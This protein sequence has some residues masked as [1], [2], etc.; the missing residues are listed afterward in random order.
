MAE[1]Q[2]FTLNTKEYIVSAIDMEIQAA[3]NPCP[4]PFPGTLNRSD[5]TSIVGWLR[6]SNHDPEDAP[7]HNEV[8]WYHAQNTMRR[9]ACNYSQ[10]LLGRLN[11]I[12][13]CLSRDRHLSKIQFAVMLTSLHPSLF[14][15]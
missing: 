8:A 2:S 7:I 4:N 13:D 5:N 3:H 11:I 9:N 6:T 14:P 1:R 10:H 15:S 12:A